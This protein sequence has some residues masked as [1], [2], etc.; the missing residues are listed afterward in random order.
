MMD[1][2]TSKAV[3]NPPAGYVVSRYE[4]LLDNRACRK[5][6]PVPFYFDRYKLSE[7]ARRE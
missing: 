2:P 7:K 5:N 6:V 3:V 4:W 1:S